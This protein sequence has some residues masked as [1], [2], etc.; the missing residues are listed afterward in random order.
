M[1]T[2]SWYAIEEAIWIKKKVNHLD[3][4]EQNVGRNALYKWVSVSIIV[5]VLGFSRVPELFQ[6][7]N[8]HKIILNNIFQW[9]KSP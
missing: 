1:C 2:I 4:V 8:L 6:Y 5:L 9:P 3:S 7:I